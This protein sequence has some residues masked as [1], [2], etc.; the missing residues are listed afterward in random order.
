MSQ[1]PATDN[2]PFTAVAVGL[3][4]DAKGRVLLAQRPQGKAYA[5]WWEF[6]GGKLEAGETV[7]Q[8]L[9]RELQEEL[10]IQIH[11]SYPWV[12]RQHSYEHARVKLFFHRVFAW[13][14]LPQTLEGQQFMWSD[15]ASVGT[16]DRVKPLLPAALP[17]LPWLALPRQVD[18]STLAGTYRY[19]KC[20]N[21]QAL[22]ALPAQSLDFV[23]L[24]PDAPTDLAGLA[25]VPCYAHE[26]Q[27]YR[28]DAAAV[29]GY[30]REATGP[31]LASGSS[32]PA[33]DSNDDPAIR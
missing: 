13:T 19:T 1:D 31:E 9:A 2:R 33:G 4:F 11:R 7:G 18:E 15:A 10:G 22:L 14:G 26:S 16:D 17:L 20:A 32:S 12:V 3:L 23:L 29:Q 25:D 6:P 8:A 5:G 28:F 24:T 21:Q 27:R 30:W